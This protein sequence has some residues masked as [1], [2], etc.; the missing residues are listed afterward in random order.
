MADVVGMYVAIQN[1]LIKEYEITLC[2]GCCPEY[3]GICD[4]FGTVPHR[5]AYYDFDTGENKRIGNWEQENT[6]KSTFI[7]LHEIGHTIYYHPISIVN[8]YLAYVFAIRKC[9]ELG[10]NLSRD[11]VL[12]NQRCLNRLYSRD[13]NKYNGAY[14]LSGMCNLDWVKT[15]ED[16]NIVKE[17]D[18]VYDINLQEYLNKKLMSVNC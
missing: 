16:Y 1:R 8:E 12:S 5:C 4:N 11:L 9:K 13:V 14:Q 3:C 6:V 10:L 18:K 7:L 17:Y 2:D 15:A